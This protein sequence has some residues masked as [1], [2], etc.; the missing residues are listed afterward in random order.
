MYIVMEGGVNLFSK[1]PQE[2]EAHIP[3]DWSTVK[4]NL[5][6]A[7]RSLD[8][9]KLI[10]SVPQASELQS[11]KK[12]DDDD[13]PVPA[14]SPDPK[15]SVPEGSSTGLAVYDDDES[16]HKFNARKTWGRLLGGVKLG[17]VVGHVTDELEKAGKKMHNRG[18]ESSYI[19]RVDVGDSFGEG[20]LVRRR[21]GWCVCPLVL[22]PT[23]EVSPAGIG[24]SAIPLRLLDT[25]PLCLSSPLKIT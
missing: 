18:L 14:P 3:I 16:G 17:A 15:A 10:A 8:A 13:G 5:Q 9:V 25:T 20:G 6:S 12:P 21:P 24:Q 1:S 19:G 4:Q 2:D 7:Q 22:S 23:C 11:I